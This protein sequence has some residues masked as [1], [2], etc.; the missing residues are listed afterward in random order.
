NCHGPGAAHVAAENG[1]DATAQAQMRA[2][3][4]VSL[5]TIER[6]SCVKCHD[7][8]NSPAFKFDDYW[9]KIAH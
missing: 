5:E 2:L 3:M 4:H 8:D 9:S 6:T 1:N 7:H